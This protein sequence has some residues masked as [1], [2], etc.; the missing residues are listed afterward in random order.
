ML[1]V[2]ITTLCLDPRIQTRFDMLHS[3]L[4]ST[5]MVHFPNPNKPYLLF[6]HVSKFCYSGMLTQ[7]STED[8]NEAFLRMLTITSEDPLES[9]ESQTQKH[10][11]KSTSFIL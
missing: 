10:Q 9:V 11:L 3:Q 4:T 7:A 5:P 8:L 2:Q 1:N 6:T